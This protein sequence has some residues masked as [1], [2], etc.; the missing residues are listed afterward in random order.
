MENIVILL[1]ESWPGNAGIFTI[2]LLFCNDRSTLEKIKLCVK[3]TLKNKLN[4]SLNKKRIIVE[5]KGASTSLK[6]K[7]Y[8]FKNLPKT[9]WSLFTI[10]LKNNFLMETKN[11][12]EL[13]NLL[14]R[15]ILE[16]IKFTNTIKT[17]QLI[18]D[19]C[20]NKEQIKKFNSSIE[21]HLRE[22]LP[23]GTRLFIEHENSRENPAI[24]AVDLFNWGIYRKYTKR[25]SEW[26][27]FY[28]NHIEIE[29]ALERNKTAP[30]IPVS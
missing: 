3:R 8:F 25:D 29:I 18:V 23:G 17:V 15:F 27:D 10:I 14:V 20:K 16:K 28:K 2:T 6:I 19:K 4:L 22:L 24:Q 21:Q 30:L 12:H 1:D 11:D 5:L 9:G 26:Y 13:Y 7:E